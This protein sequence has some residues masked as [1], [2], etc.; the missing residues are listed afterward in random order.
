ME[1][2]P[3]KTWFLVL[4]GLV[5]VGLLAY[6]PIGI[7]GIESLIFYKIFWAALYTHI[8]EAVVVAVLA[9]RAGQAVAPWFGQTLALGYSSTQAFF[10]AQGSDKKVLLPCLGGFAVVLAL[11]FFI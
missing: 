11:L 7:P 3:P 5:I 8:G 2:L 10:T 4:G 6:A 9:Q 1:K